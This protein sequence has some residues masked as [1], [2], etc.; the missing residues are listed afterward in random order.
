[1]SYSTTAMTEDKDKYHSQRERWEND[2]EDEMNVLSA[3]FR[4]AHTSEQSRPMTVAGL[5][6]PEAISQLER[7]ASNFEKRVKTAQPALGGVSSHV[8]RSE[9]SGTT[10]N[11]SDFCS[12]ASFFKSC[13]VLTL[14]DSKEAF[15]VFAT[16]NRAGT[17]NDTSSVVAYHTQQPDLN[18]HKLLLEREDLLQRLAAIDRLV[19]GQKQQ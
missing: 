13:E 14:E 3:A 5:A 7:D 16:D 18:T 10:S 6:V 15:D 17:H 1:M 8:W 2:F 9:R 4:K 11:A 12:T 19:Q